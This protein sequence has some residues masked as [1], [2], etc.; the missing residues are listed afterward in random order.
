MR[1]IF[2]TAAL[3]AVF[4]ALCAATGGVAGA[5]EMTDYPIVRLRSLDKTTARSKTFEVRVGSTVRFGSIYIKVQ[6]CRKPPPIE[7]PE[8]AAFLQVW[9]NDLKTGEPKWVF[10][11]WMF[12]SSPA[13][14]AM[15]HPI[16]DVWV[17]DCIDDA[18]PPAAA[19]AENG[20]A[21]S[22]QTGTEGT[23]TGETGT[24]ETKEAPPQTGE[25]E[26]PVDSEAVMDMPD[27][28]AAPGPS[29]TQQ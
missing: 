21:A 23:G 15:D 25:I 18:P 7:K 9:E 20:A 3:L 24:R 10:S 26:T 13:L 1:G 22:P 19:A 5:G 28:D 4:F 6:S 17:L 16:Y 14:S 27:G 29:E 8:S 2:R 12:A 11:G